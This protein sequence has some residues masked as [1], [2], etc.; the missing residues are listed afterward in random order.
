MPIHSS[1][2]ICC[3]D[4]E[5]KPLS[6]SHDLI[7][8]RKSTKNKRLTNCTRIDLLQGRLNK[9]IRIQVRKERLQDL[10]SRGN[11]TQWSGSL[12][13][14]IESLATPVCNCD[15]SISQTITSVRVRFRRD[16]MGCNELIG[17]MN[18]CDRSYSTP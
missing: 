16:L 18:E 5:I 2:P 7:L 1:P 17:L 10:G 12:A 14:P 9:A 3:I 13:F 15:V 6:C 4:V 11:I 8:Q